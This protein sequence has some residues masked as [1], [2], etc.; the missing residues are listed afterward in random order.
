MTDTDKIKSKIFEIESEAEFHKLALD[1]FDYQYNNVTVYREFCNLM[2]VTKVGTISEIPFLPISFFKSHRV[3]DQLSLNNY[4]TLFKSSGTSASVRSKHY[5]HN[6]KLYEQSFLSCFIRFF[7]NP[8]DYAI[9]GLLPN[10][11]E[12][13]ESSLVYMVDF[14]I[15]HSNYKDSGFYLNNYQELINEVLKLKQQGHQKIIIFGVSYALMDLADLNPAFSDVIIVETGGM[16]GRRK[17][18][19]KEDLHSYLK[20]GFSVENIHSE[21]GMTELLSQAYFLEDSFQTPPW[22]KVLIRDVNDP[23]SFL[24][25][26]KT[27]ALNVIDLA[28][29]HSCSFLA[30]DDLGKKIG[31]N[32]QVMGRLDNSDVRGCNLLLSS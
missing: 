30:T 15:K 24:S 4:D 13:G 2:N 9:F 22:M 27:G 5:I 28:N 12:Q 18:L 25:D 29:I 21:Y 32:F 1:V 8:K 17:E 10:Y 6:I 23:K 3:V 31:E 16:K 26:E 19:L 14:L 7:G 20:N 11:L